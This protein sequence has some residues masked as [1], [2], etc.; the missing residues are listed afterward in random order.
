MHGVFQLSRCYHVLPF[1]IAFIQH[2]QALSIKKPVFELDS[3]RHRTTEIRSTPELEDEAA[4]PTTT[5]NLGLNSGRQ[6]RIIGPC[7]IGRGGTAGV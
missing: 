3:K 2:I 1:L 6:S 7:D 5:L 4:S